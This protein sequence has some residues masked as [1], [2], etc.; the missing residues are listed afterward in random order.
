MIYEHLKNKYIWLFSSFIKVKELIGNE[1]KSS[2]ALISNLLLSLIE[3][4][5][6]ELILLL[7]IFTKSLLNTLLITNCH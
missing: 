1:Y 6:V 7:P 5:D 3:F 2:T 4:N